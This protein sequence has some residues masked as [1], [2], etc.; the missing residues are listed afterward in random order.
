V[1]DVVGS[2]R[3]AELA[4]DLGREWTGDGDFLIRGVAPLESASESELSYVRTG[5]WAASAARSRAGALILPEDVDPGGRPAIHSP[6]PGLD[7]ARAVRRICPNSRPASGIHPAAHVD[8]EAQVDASAS[9]GAASVVGAGSSIGARSILHANVTIYHDVE[10]G[11]DCELHAGVVVREGSR[12]GKRVCLEP[13]VLIGGDGFGY[14][15]DERGRFEKVPQVGRVRI[16]DDVEI[17]AGSTVDRATLSETRIR[18]GAKI[19]NLVQI[20]HNC[21]VGEGAVIAA[22]SGLSGSTVIGPGAIVMAQAGSAGHLRVGAGAFVGARAGLHRDVPDGARVWGSP[23]ME[24][25]SW[26]RAVAALARLPEA[27]RR[28]RAVERKLG[29]RG[30]SKAA[31]E[32]GLGE[33]TQASGEDTQARGEDTQA[34]DA[35]GLGAS[36]GAGGSEKRPS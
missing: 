17:G 4:T 23:Q 3:L 12:I 31:E 10:I 34:A 20:A 9:I 24:E 33:D 30:A 1:T 26:H 5:A 21:D 15:H 2:L 27:L 16:E 7:F 6:N 14:I 22:Q 29:L 28:L 18:R 32:E 36:G 8:P 11:E 35:T 13:G 19:D 25:R